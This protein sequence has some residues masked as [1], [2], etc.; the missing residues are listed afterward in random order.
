ML[1]ILLSILTILFIITLF[2]HPKLSPIPFF[3]T[4]KKDLPFIIK[5]LNLKNNQTI[6]D[7][8]AGDG[9]VVFTAANKA[10]L[11]NLNTVF[12]AVEINPILVLILHLRRLSHPNKK[13]IKIIWGDMFKINLKSQILNRKSTSQNSNL[14]VMKQCNNVTIYLYI[15]P[16]LINQLIDRLKQQQI[17]HSLI[18]YMYPSKLLKNK[19][20]IL[21]GLHN[22]YVYN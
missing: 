10:L 13:N 4:N 21:R 8:G 19:E 15:S 3:P 9:V 6:F 20:K 22:I 17:N 1:F 14:S 11:K 12:V 18:S 5:A 2:S 16:W 7:L